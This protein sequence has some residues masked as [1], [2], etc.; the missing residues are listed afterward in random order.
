MQTIAELTR[1]IAQDG[2]VTWI[3]LRPARRA[4]MTVVET[5]EIAAN[6]LVGDHARG[7]SR[8]VTLLQAEHLAVIAA[9]LGHAA[10]S[11]GG[12]GAGS[13][14]GSRTGSGTGTGIRAP[15]DPAHLRRNIVV[16]GV[17]L[18]ALRHREIRIG[19]AVLA[20]TGPAA[21][22]SRMEETLGH[23]GYSAVR[24]HGGITASIVS[25]GQVALGDPVTLA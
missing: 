21:P 12:S 7:A 2:R 8:A 15:V 22:C 6:G 25:A 3:G 1:R 5:A 16:A 13:R 20:V 23:G 17:N 10:T 11:G 9:F 18:L 4:P 19:G 14:T 24:G